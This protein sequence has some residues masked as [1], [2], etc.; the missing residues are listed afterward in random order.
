VAHVHL[1]VLGQQREATLEVRTGEAT[2]EDLLEPARAISATAAS[3]A[4]AR[5][6]AAGDA[7]QCRAGCASCCRHLVPVS[8]VEAARL[9]AVV[10]ALPAGQR[11][12]VEAR[13]AA[14]V[15]AMERAG[16]LDA[17][18]AR[19]RHALRSAETE[20]SA[21]WLDVSRRYFAAGIAC[22]F[23]VDESCSVYEERPMVC[24]EYSA[25]SE[26][27]RCASLDGG[28]RTVERPLH[29]TEALG[30]AAAEALELTVSTLPLA[31]L[32]EWSAAHGATLREPRDGEAL[33]W[34]LMRQVD[35]AS[36]RPFEERG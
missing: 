7:V 9:A 2:V 18:A 5:A 25:L 11:E 17:R 35:A 29:M 22:P 1:R 26:P 16:L 36:E 30:R 27:A 13:F 32:L 23:L 20:R 10:A 8:V 19:G 34:T 15:T 28:V 21:A 31:L 3:V 33:F 24:R 6:H 4:V 14:A 12:G